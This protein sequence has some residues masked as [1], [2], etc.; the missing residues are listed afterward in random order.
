MPITDCWLSFKPFSHSKKG[1]L[2]FPSDCTPFPLSW[3]V[4]AKQVN[5]FLDRIWFSVLKFEEVK[6]V[7]GSNRYTVPSYVPSL[8][9]VIVRYNVD[10]SAN[11]ESQAFCYTI[12]L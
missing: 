4:S 6:K 9:T 3:K 11:Y 5:I 10:W 7:L 12:I 8:D 2:L 1:L